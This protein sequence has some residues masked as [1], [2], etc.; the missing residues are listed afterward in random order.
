MS[1]VFVN[2]DLLCHKTSEGLI[3]CQDWVL[4]TEIHLAW[5]QHGDR[6]RCVVVGRGIMDI[7]REERVGVTVGV[8]VIERKQK[9]SMYITAYASNVPRE[10]LV[11]PPNRPFLYDIAAFWSPFLPQLGWSGLETWQP[12]LLV[13]MRWISAR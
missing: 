7:V 1:E 13:I 10:W 5:Y 4:F 2:V 3:S 9:Q 6:R 11:E 12:N 8:S